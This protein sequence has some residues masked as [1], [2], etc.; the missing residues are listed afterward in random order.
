M[1]KAGTA[2]LATLLFW[3]SA[4]CNGADRAPC[5]LADE[6]GTLCGF[7]NPEDLEFV[8][9]AGVVLV[10][11]MRFDG[12]VVDGGYMIPTARSRQTHS[13]CILTAS[14]RSAAAN[15]RSCI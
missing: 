14:P 11:N 2:T 12:P 6:I 8:Q 4:G 5:S 1:R 7:R 3:A 9:H 10:S 15:E 13:R